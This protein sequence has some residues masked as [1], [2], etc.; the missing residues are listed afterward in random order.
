VTDTA[1]LE[2]AAREQL[3]YLWGDLDEARRYAHNGTW[4]LKCDALVERIKDLTALVGATPW[5]QIQIPLLEL[6]IYQRIHA[7]L[8][9]EVQPD[10]TRVAQMRAELDKQSAAIRLS[11]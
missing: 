6:G 10:M 4:S 2:E 3:A 9:I 1:R 11:S 8:G 7:E 5:D